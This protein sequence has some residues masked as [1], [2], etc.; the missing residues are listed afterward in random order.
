MC[1]FTVQSFKVIDFWTNQ[2]PVYAFLLVINCDLNLYLAPFQRYMYSAEI[3]TPHSKV[4]PHNWR[5]FRILS[6]NLS[7]WELEQFLLF[8]KNRVILLVVVLSQYTCVTD[9]DDD[10]Q[11]I[12]T[13]AELCNTVIMLITLRL[14]CLQQLNNRFFLPISSLFLQLCLC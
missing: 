2:K 5:F 3:Y 13:I 11:Y 10:R 12:T 8:N 14:Y 7:G 9:D 4:C 6:S 1:V